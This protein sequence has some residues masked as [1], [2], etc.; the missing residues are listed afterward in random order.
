MS[1]LQHLFTTAVAMSLQALQEELEM[2][3]DLRGSCSLCVQVSG[4]LFDFRRFCWSHARMQTRCGNHV[5]ST[6]QSPELYQNP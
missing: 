4:S 1:W 2:L 5:G 6:C 3:Q